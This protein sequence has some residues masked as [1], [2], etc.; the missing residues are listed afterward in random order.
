MDHL[1]L[2]PRIDALEQ[3]AQTL[4]R[5]RANRGAPMQRARCDDPRIR[6]TVGPEGGRLRR[7]PL[8]RG[9]M[10]LAVVV[11]LTALLPSPAGAGQDLGQFCWKL[12]PFVD[13]LRLTITQATGAATLFELH[14]RWRA[15]AIAGQQAAGGAGPATYQ[16]LG[17]GTATE[18]LTQPG[19]IDLGLEA[20]HNT[21]FFGGNFSCNFFAVINNVFTLS[22]SWNLQCP[23]TTPFEAEG[24]LTFQSPCPAQD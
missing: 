1:F 8:A 9:M 3:Q 4:L 21:T 2:F 10:G 16:L 6:R 22:G 11:I 24:T 19:S 17:A 15:T 12:D 18:S 13:T 5:H 7:A 14:G 20:V 23:G